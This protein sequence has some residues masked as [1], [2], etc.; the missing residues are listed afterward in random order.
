[1]N[2]D[3]NTYYVLATKDG[4]SNR[5]HYYTGN[6]AFHGGYLLGNVLEAKRFINQQQIIEFLSQDKNFWYLGI[7]IIGIS[8]VTFEAIADN[9][10]L[11]EKYH[12]LSYVIK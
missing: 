7:N 4:E 10:E 11:Y 5:L 1:M 2:K 8:G 3:F 9:K 6:E 12:T